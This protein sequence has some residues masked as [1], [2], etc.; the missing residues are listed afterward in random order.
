MKREQRPFIITGCARSGTAYTAKL[1]TAAGVPC[2][3]EEVF[4]LAAVTALGEASHLL[5]WSDC[6]PKEASWLAAPLLDQLPKDI[7]VFHQL[8]NP[9]HVIRSLMR[10]RFFHPDR[11][12]GSKYAE[13]AKWWMNQGLPSRLAHHKINKGDSPLTRCM[14]YWVGWNQ[15]VFEH[16]TLREFTAGGALAYRVG[17][18]SADQLVLPT[19]LKMITGSWVPSSTDFFDRVPVGINHTSVETDAEAD[20]ITWEDLPEGG[21]KRSL[22]QMALAW[23]YGGKNHDG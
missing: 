13:Y 3:H 21:T 5:D 22:E 16:G 7:V 20:A 11:G 19:I 9:L 14:K 15:L 1:L 23:G 4:S 12:T 17:D 10:R 18:L 8:R 2:P 6:Y